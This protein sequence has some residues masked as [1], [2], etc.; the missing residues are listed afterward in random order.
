[1]KGF[2]YSKNS[3]AF[4]G[5]LIIF[6]VGITA[7]VFSVAIVGKYIQDNEI[8]KIMLCIG[9]VIVLFILLAIPLF[10]L[11]PAFF[12]KKRI[13]PFCEDYR[14]FLNQ[15]DLQTDFCPFENFSL[16]LEYLT[17]FNDD[18]NETIDNIGK[19][20][21]I[22][23][24]D[25]DLCT[26]VSYDNSFMLATIYI[27]TNLDENNYV[28]DAFFILNQATYEYIKNHNIHV[29]GLDYLLNHLEQ[30]ITKHNSKNLRKT[31]FID[32]HQ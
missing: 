20:G 31:F 8:G 7:I 15:E 17:K 22:D 28:H 32:Y 18:D 19:M 9:F 2:S 23:I 3:S 11:S 5:A 29:A 30:E 26:S 14:K 10:Y 13:K 4:L 25:L 21:S 6:V 16:P 24:N 27:C 1:M 12:K